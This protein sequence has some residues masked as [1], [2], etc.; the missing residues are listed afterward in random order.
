MNHDISDDE[1]GL[2]SD[3]ITSI[4]DRL[5]RVLADGRQVLRPRAHIYARVLFAVISSARE[6]SGAFGAGLLATPLLEPLN[7]APA[8]EEVTALDHL[9]DA[10]IAEHTA[11]AN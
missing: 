8:R 5:D 11:P 2:I 3:I 9:I 4:D 10:T 7:N 6:T 1:I